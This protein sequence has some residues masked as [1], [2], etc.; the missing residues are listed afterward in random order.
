[1]TRLCE[2]NRCQSGDLPCPTPTLCTLERGLEKA[3]G[4]EAAA[5]RAQ[6]RLVQRNEGSLHRAQAVKRERRDLGELLLSSGA[7]T[8]PHRAPKPI[9][10]GLDRFRRQ[11]RAA[12]SEVVKSINE[13][14][15][16]WKLRL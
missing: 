13:R 1:M 5:R 11:M 6:L 10:P 14:V 12:W 9:E 8:G 3:R 4:I 7:V 2:T 15:M 16:R